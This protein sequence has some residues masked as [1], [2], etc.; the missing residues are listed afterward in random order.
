MTKWKKSEDIYD[1]KH[2]GEASQHFVLEKP[3]NTPC[4]VTY[5]LDMWSVS[6]YSF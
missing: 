6:R 5:T 2:S 1:Q 3:T 4:V